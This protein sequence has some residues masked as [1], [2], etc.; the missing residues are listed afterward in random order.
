MAGT[1]ERQ[2]ILSTHRAVLVLGTISSALS[3]LALIIIIEAPQVSSY[4]ASVLEPFDDI[5]LVLIVLSICLPAVS[6][7]FVITRSSGPTPLRHLVPLVVPGL[8]SAIGIL[9]LPMSRGYLFYGRG[10]AIAQLGSC[11]ELSYGGHVLPDDIYPSSHIFM[12]IVSQAAGIDLRVLFLTMP[13]ILAIAFSLAAYSI[14]KMF[15]CRTALVSMILSLFILKYYQPIPYVFGLLFGILS[16]WMFLR[17]IQAEK[18]KGYS[19]TL[20]LIVCAMPLVH[21]Y[22]AL[23]LMIIMAS[24]TST[25]WLL[26]KDGIISRARLRFGIAKN[27]IPRSGFTEWQVVLAVN[28]FM[29][30]IMTTLMTLGV[31]IVSRLVSGESGSLYMEVGRL[32]SRSNLDSIDI[33]SYVARL[34]LVYVV[35]FILSLIGFRYYWS[36]RNAL[37]RDLKG[38]IWPYIGV[39]VMVLLILQIASLVYPIGVD[40]WRL[41]SNLYLVLITL[42]AASVVVICRI[43]AITTPRYARRTLA[44]AWSALLAIGL[45]SANSV[46]GGYHSE[47][48]Y[49]PNELVTNSERQALVFLVQHGNSSTDVHSLSQADRIAYEV[50]AEL[51]L[52]EYS[53]FEPSRRIPDHFGYNTHQF[54]GE[55]LASDAYFT[56]FE[57]DRMNY[58]ELWAESGIFTVNDFMHLNLDSSAAKILESGD[59][60]VYRITSP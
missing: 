17:L 28:W 43:P 47:Y 7:L 49:S 6:S 22:S 25:I 41:M 24:I 8:L 21:P 18:A 34:L 48:T 27:E 32:V 56:L 33:V 38:A 36:Q 15:G 53:Y 31:V 2:S 51:Q 55:L 1:N 12:V 5:E 52:T 14:G 44:F 16:L 58:V 46:L 45:A 37:A 57:F 40:I 9:L 42:G 29:W 26:N 13:F 10:D 20:G 4:E 23:A 50:A 3:L 59:A 35:L 39:P 54:L 60:S 19:L 30:S 11:L